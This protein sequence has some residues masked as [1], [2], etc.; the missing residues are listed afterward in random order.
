MMKLLKIRV[1]TIFIFSLVSAASLSYAEEKIDYTPHIHGTVRTRFELATE[2]G[3]YRFQVRNARVSLDGKIAPMIDYYVNAD[4]C[5][6]G[7]IKILDVWARIYA[8]KTLGFQAGQFRMPFGV[9]PFRGPNTY[10]FANRS[11]IGKQVCNVRAVG[12][13]A[14]YALPSV[15][16]SIEAGAFSPT[17]IGNHSGWNNSLAF[18]AKATYTIDNVKIATGFQSIIPDSVRTNL[19][20]AAVSWS[21]G[22]WFIE[23]EYMYK[24]YAAR[25]HKACHAYMLQADYQM[26]I[27]AGIFNRLSFQGRFDGMTDHSNALRDEDGLL[28]TNDPARNRVTVGATISYIKSK[29][30]FLHLRAN[31]EKYFYRHDV[32][33]TPD[34]GD[35]ALIELVLRF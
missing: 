11:F 8:T 4:M 30:L 20:D 3:K 28:T 17:T 1:F 34:S 14:M 29:N 31:Y 32:T 2:S 23:G 19:V 35:K 27:K 24:H 18:A 9:D 21:S 26:P 33:T 12:V 10:I 15:P 25:R 16:L 5:D 13:K 22:R 7:S 6:R